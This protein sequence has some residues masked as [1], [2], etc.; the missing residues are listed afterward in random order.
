MSPSIARGRKEEPIDYTEISTLH[1]DPCPTTVSL[2]AT[3]PTPESRVS[4]HNT[5][6]GTVSIDVDIVGCWPGCGRPPSG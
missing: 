3:F 4:A 1:V 6:A 5:S 2:Q